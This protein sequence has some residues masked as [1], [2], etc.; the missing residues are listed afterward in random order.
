[1]KKKKEVRDNFFKNKKAI[2]NERRQPQNNAKLA[3]KPAKI[4]NNQP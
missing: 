1:M 4:Q 3:A 2:M